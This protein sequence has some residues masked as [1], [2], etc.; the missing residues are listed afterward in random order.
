MMFC[1]I[2]HSFMNFSN[3]PGVNY[4]SLPETNVFC[5][6][7]FQTCHDGDRNWDVSKLPCAG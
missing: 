4:R 6:M 5:K 3:I 7:P 1:V 2:S